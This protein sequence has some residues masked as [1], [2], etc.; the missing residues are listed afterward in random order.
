MASS[1]DDEALLKRF[2]KNKVLIC[3]NSASERRT[4][5]IEKPKVYFSCNKLFLKALASLQAR[6]VTSWNVAP[7]AGPAKPH[8]ATADVISRPAS[9]AAAQ[10]DSSDDDEAILAHKA[11]VLPC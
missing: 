7:K 10:L 4:A 1:S 3:L 6:R 8:R 11:K 2:E 5:I 9:A